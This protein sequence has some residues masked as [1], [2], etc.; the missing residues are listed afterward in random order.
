MESTLASLLHGFADYLARTPHP[1]LHADIVGYR[2]AIF[3]ATDDEFIQIL[4]TMNQAL[5][6]LISSTEPGPGRKQRKLASITHPIP[7]VKRE[8]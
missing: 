5:A 1:D 6:P 2:E 3:Y 8:T 4:T 7:D